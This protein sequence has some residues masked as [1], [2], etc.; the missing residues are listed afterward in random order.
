[1]I[2]SKQN[3]LIKEIRSLENKKFRDNLGKYVALGIKLTVEAFEHGQK[4]ECVVCTEEASKSLGELP[5]QK[6]LVTPEV[7]ETLSEEKKRRINAALNHYAYSSLPESI[8]Y[9]SR[10]LAAV[11]STTSS[12]RAGAGG[13]LS[14][15]KL[16]R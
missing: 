5:T 15:S 2:T 10:Y 7:F 11:F 3:P 8:R 6:I 13:F 14:Q 1:M 9:A 16:S 12:G 4:V